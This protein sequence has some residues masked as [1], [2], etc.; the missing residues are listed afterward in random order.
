[1]QPFHLLPF[2]Q[3]GHASLLFVT[4]LV[5]ILNGCSLF[6][7]DRKLNKFLSSTLLINSGAMLIYDSL[8]L[9]GYRRFESLKIS[10]LFIQVIIGILS[11]FFVWGH[12]YERWQK[13][14]ERTRKETTSINRPNDKDR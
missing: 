9:I 4:G 6:F 2:S 8:N 12:H 11:I 5:S 7:N 3:S 10:T 14:R 13:I 1:M